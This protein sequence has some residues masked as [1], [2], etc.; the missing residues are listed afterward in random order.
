[1]K[2]ISAVFP[3]IPGDPETNVG[4]MIVTGQILPRPSLSCPQAEPPAISLP[5]GHT[6]V[7]G[8]CHSARRQTMPPT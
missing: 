3:V 7:G 2:L 5:D 6:K 1:M 4:K 8:C